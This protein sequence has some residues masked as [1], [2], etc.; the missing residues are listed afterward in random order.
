MRMGFHSSSPR[1]RPTARN[2]Q[3]TERG[4]LSGGLRHLLRLPLLCKPTLCAVQLRFC[5]LQIVHRFGRRASSFFRILFRLSIDT[6]VSSSRV[7][8]LA[9]FMLSCC[10]RC[11]SYGGMFAIWT[12]ILPIVVGLIVFGKPLCFGDFSFGNFPVLIVIDPGGERERER[13]DHNIFG[14]GCGDSGR[15]LFAF[16]WRRITGSL[17]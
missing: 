2:T 12:K 15:I 10:C 8:S 4:R 13:G 17:S 7:S 3:Q 11:L 14:A 16:F 1:K 9:G 6:F 5:G